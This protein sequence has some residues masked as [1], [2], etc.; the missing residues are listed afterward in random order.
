M[1]VWEAAWTE[2]CALFMSCSP[3][4]SEFLPGLQLFSVTI[5]SR[6]A[7]VVRFNLRTTVIYCHV[8]CIH[9]EMS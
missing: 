6:G 4:I 2:Q 5:C 3:L 9:C 7:S 8:H 1:K